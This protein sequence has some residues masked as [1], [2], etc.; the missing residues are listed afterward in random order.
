MPQHSWALS[1]LLSDGRSACSRSRSRDTDLNTALNRLLLEIKPPLP[2]TGRPAWIRLDA[3]PPDDHPGRCQELLNGMRQHL[4]VPMGITGDP[5]ERGPQRDGTLRL[6]LD[7]SQACV[8]Q[9]LRVHDAQERARGWLLRRLERSGPPLDSLEALTALLLLRGT[10][11]RPD[12][13]MACYSQ[14]LAVLNPITAEP[15]SPHEADLRAALGLAVLAEQRNDGFQ[16]DPKLDQRC[17]DLQQQLLATVDQL[18]KSLAAPAVFSLTLAEARGLPA[19]GWQGPLQT[20]ID[21]LLQH[22]RGASNI[23]IWLLLSLLAVARSKA[24]LPDSLR[25]QLS[26]P[27][28]LGVLAGLNAAEQIDDLARALRALLLLQLSDALRIEPIAGD[29]ARLL[30]Q[31]TRVVLAQQCNAAQ[32]IEAPDPQLE[33]GGFGW[34]RAGDSPLH[35]QWP[36]LLALLL[37]LPLHDRHVAV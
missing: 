14:T 27:G 36:A 13:A 7:I 21:W 8:P 23:R 26:E 9:H 32:A 24:S 10:N 16:N 29:P 37:L 1:L 17:R 25:R 33:L 3:T 2:A 31:A 28:T 35:Q 19:S 18:P 5:E 11:D 12:L 6:W 20:L 22:G 30:D 4:L 15:T 34:S